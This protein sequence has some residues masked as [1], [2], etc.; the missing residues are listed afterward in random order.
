MHAY[1]SLLYAQL[2]VATHERLV[3]GLVLVSAE[4]NVVIADY[5]RRK[6]SIVRDLNGSVASRNLK[7]ALEGILRKSEEVNAQTD[8]LF[9]G[10]RVEDSMFSKNYLKYLSAYSSNLLIVDPPRRID[11][12]ANDNTFDFLYVDGVDTEGRYQSNPNTHQR[13]FVELKKR[14]LVRKH[15]KA[16]AKIDE[17]VYSGVNFP[18]KVDLAGQNGQLTVAKLV[19]TDRQVRFINDDAHAFQSLLTQTPDAKHFLVSS[20]P[21]KSLEPKQHYLWENLRDVFGKQYLD[22]SEFGQLEAYAE[23][24]GVEPLG[25]SEE[26]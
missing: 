21:S 23:E 3:V 11:L 17:S 16:D 14:D 18:V 2:N 5:S 22:L 20:E 7:W 6:L 8:N 13:R 15:F 1:Y 19:A 24:H 4:E 12:P 25:S 9:S 10:Q 26:E